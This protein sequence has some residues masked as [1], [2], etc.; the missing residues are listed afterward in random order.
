M[1]IMSKYARLSYKDNL[2][3]T[4]NEIIAVYAGII[5]DYYKSISA[6][7]YCSR[8]IVLRGVD[9]VTTVFNHIIYY[10]RNIELAISYSEKAYLFY[11]E[12]ISQI[13]DAE[14]LFLKL[15]SRDAAVYVFN[16]T[17][18]EI[19]YT[20]AKPNEETEQKYILFNK[21]ANVIKTLILKYESEETFNKEVE[22]ILEHGLT[23][24]VIRLIDAEYYKTG[25]NF[26]ETVIGLISNQ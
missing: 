10:T 18:A 7:H 6:E 16:K 1:R 15:S 4:V 17:I 14:K 25:N 2:E 5:R 3:M 20:M 19:N 9:T 8:F 11:I 24:Q 21:T 22:L 26:N 13:S 23:D 12:F